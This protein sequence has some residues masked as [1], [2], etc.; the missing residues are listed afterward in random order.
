M[1]LIWED[2][3]NGQFNF[4]YDGWRRTIHGRTTSR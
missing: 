1:V 3:G 2:L 4:V